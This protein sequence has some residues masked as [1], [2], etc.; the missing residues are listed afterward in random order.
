MF[1]LLEINRERVTTHMEKEDHFT[2]TLL[3]LHSHTAAPDSKVAALGS[4]SLS[5][6][7]SLSLLGSLSLF[8]LK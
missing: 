5:L 4:P 2:Q 6:L 7:F 1:I 3:P 8:A